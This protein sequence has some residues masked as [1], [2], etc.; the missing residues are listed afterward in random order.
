MLIETG[1]F[2]TRGGKKKKKIQKDKAQYMTLVDLNSHS[3]DINGSNKSDR[4]K[5]GDGGG[6]T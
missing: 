4:K 3:S 1:Y 5:E 6:N 2:V